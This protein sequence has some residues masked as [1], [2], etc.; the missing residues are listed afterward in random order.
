MWWC[1]WWPR[2]KTPYLFGLGENTLECRLK[3]SI[4]QIVGQ[5]Y[6]N[7]IT[8]T[9]A[10]ATIG[11]YA[12]YILFMGGMSG[13][14]LSLAVALL[15]AAFVDHLEY[16]AI[17]LVL[18]GLVYVLLLQ[19]TMARYYLTG[20][21][22]KE[23][24]AA[25]APGSLVPED[26]A[27]SSKMMGSGKEISDRVV[28]M[29][30]GRYSPRSGV[31]GVLSDGA[32]GHAPATTKNSRATAT[33][34]AVKKQGFLNYGVYAEGFEDAAVAAG[35]EKGEEEKKEGAPAESE[36]A[37]ATKTMDAETV[38][39]QEQK[40]VE[41]TATAASAATA[42]FQG[43]QASLF[44]LGEM[45]SESKEGPH[46][47]VAATMQNA[48]SALNPDQMAAMTRE[49]QSLVETQKN[50][51]NMLQSMRPVLQ[52]GRQLLDTFSGIFGNLQGAG[53]LGKAMGGMGGL[54]L[55]KM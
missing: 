43:G 48:L 5:M 52:D 2:P 55:G 15:T 45:P 37:P 6:F 11:L 31:Q 41:Q 23:G 51:M 22:G 17:A 13:L 16:I 44:K 4:L 28:A 19:R 36:A 35:N 18:F 25:P 26:Y 24:F 47:D 33:I 42:G 49:S 53:G 3:D 12:L 20:A 38:T 54:Q 34:K 27:E 30:E 10:V 29:K 14:L 8:F 9:I 32:D 21:A 7:S 40:K 50:L 46:V 39:T 1:R